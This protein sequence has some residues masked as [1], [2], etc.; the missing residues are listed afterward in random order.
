MRRSVHSRTV[1]VPGV[2]APAGDL[3]SKL[4]PAGESA[5]GYGKNKKAREDSPDSLIS[6]SDRRQFLGG[7]GVGLVFVLGLG[8]P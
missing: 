3:S 7:P 4:K 5:Q 1:C 6:L 8:A 2:P